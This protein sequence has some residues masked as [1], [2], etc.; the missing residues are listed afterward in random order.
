MLCKHDLYACINCG[1]F[2][3]VASISR[4]CLYIRA[5]YRLLE[6]GVT[7]WYQSRGQSCPD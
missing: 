2:E 3:D 7:S 1:L 6:I 4:I 5:F